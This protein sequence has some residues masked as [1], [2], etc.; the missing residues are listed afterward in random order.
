MKFSIIGTGFIFPSHV[1]AIR[2]VGGEI[3]DIV[4]NNRGSDSWKEMVSTTKADYIVI[5]TPNDLHSEMINFSLQNGKKVLC[6]KPLVINSQEIESLNNDVFT[7]LQ[8][9]HHP[10]AKELKEQVSKEKKYKIEMNISVYRDNH[11]HDC[12]KGQ[13]EHSGGILFNLGIHYFDL[14]L[15]LFGPAQEIKTEYLDDKKAQG[16]ISSNNYNC[17]WQV[18]INSSRDNQK[19]V[20]KINNIDYNFSSKDNLSFE[21]LHYFIYK[22]LLEGK[23]V[24]PQEAL[25]SIKL[26]EKIYDSSNS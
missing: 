5:L 20:F 8:L 25:K 11:Y 10:L 1:Q 19:R 18:N 23:G 21:N 4:N 13:K 22:D 15:Y 7:V 9:R 12:W 16:I 6:E 17:S 2:D 26:V 14:L 24:F 3:I